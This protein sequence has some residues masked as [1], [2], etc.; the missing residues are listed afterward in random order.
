MRKASVVLGIM[1]L[2][3]SGLEAQEL[4]KDDELFM[5]GYS[6]GMVEVYESQITNAYIGLRLL[7]DMDEAKAY[8]KILVSSM[9]TALFSLW[10]VADEVT[11]RPE[12]LKILAGIKSAN[13]KGF[14]EK[15]KGL[16]NQN[17]W[18]MDEPEQEKKV[19]W[20]LDQ[21]IEYGNIY[22]FQNL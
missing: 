8:R 13:F 10:H 21:Y 9:N 18:L 16:R 3:G 22:G 12:M 6:A 5:K 2:A 7:K 14:F 4:S 15:L 11:I 20:V 19:Q 1:L 17:N